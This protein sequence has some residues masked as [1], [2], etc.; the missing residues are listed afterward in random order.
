MQS[1][2]LLI[3]LIIYTTSKATAIPSGGNCIR[4]TFN[5]ELTIGFY[6][7]RHNHKKHSFSLFYPGF[8]RRN[9]YLEH[10]RNNCQGK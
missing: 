10:R 4:Y 2:L 7:Y 8:I 9:K 5:Y 6:F 1:T 3:L